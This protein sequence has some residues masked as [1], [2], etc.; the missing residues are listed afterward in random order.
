MTALSDELQKLQ[1]ESKK[2]RAIVETYEAKEPLR[3]LVSTGET[4]KEVQ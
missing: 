3:V 4:A 1:D 2:L